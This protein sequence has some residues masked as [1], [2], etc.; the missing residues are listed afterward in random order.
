MHKKT[1][2]GWGFSREKKILP[3]RHPLVGGH[4]LAD[5][6]QSATEAQS[7]QITYTQSM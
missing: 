1:A 2:V 5:G 7:V 6:S 4:T 3:G